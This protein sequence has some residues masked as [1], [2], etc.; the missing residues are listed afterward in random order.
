[1]SEI[2]NGPNNKIRRF[3]KKFIVN[4]SWTPF[5]GAQ[6]QMTS[7]FHLQSHCKIQT[8][9]NMREGNVTKIMLG[10]LCTEARSRIL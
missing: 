5:Q 3:E 4:I 8:M 9:I 10:L 2:S 7:A 6:M 1:M